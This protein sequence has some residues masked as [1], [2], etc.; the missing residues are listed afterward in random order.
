[1]FCGVLRHFIDRGKDCPKVLA[2]THFHDVF[3]QDLLDAESL[4]IAFLHMQVLFTNAN[5]DLVGASDSVNLEANEFDENET[6]PGALVRP[7][8]R[9][10]YLYR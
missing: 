9:I 1:M 10:T 3:R 2:A 5:G 7:G 6:D 8:E 4:P